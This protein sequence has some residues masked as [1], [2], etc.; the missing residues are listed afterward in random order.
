MEH[1][2]L[3]FVQFIEFFCD[4]LGVR[5]FAAIYYTKVEG[6]LFDFFRFVDYLSQNIP[7]LFRVSFICCENICVIH[8]LSSSFY[9]IKKFVVF[10]KVI[11]VTS[12]GLF[13]FLLNNLSLFID[14]IISP[15]VIQRSCFISFF[16]TLMC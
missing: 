10:C 4:D 13:S 14:D 15:F 7:S 9:F 8:F 3:H 1:Y 6:K 12:F 5:N 11:Y 2:R 16:L